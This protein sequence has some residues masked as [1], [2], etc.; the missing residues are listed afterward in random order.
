MTFMNTPSRQAPLLFAAAI[1]IGAALAPL[2]AFAINAPAQGPAPFHVE[3]ATIADIQRAILAHQ[4][5][6]TDLVRLYLARIKAFNGQAVEEPNGILEPI[7]TIPHAR[8]LNALGTL[9]LRPAT[10]R[11]M[12]FDEHKARSMTDPVDADPNMPDAFEVAAK[13]DAEFARTGRLAGPLHGVVFAIKDQYDTFDMRTTSGADAAYAN[14]RP[15]RDSTF[16][17]RLREA[18]AIILAKAN[19]GEYA[20]SYGGN[21]SSFGGTVVNAYDTERTPG[22]SSA[23]SGAAVAA[24]LVS[25]AMGE[26]TSPSIRAPAVNGNAVG[27]AA[28]QE[29]VS[30]VG[31]MNRGINTRVGPITRTV[32]DAARVLSVIAGYD[33][34]DE[35]TAFSV[36]RIP[37]RT[38]ESFTHETNLKGMRI[39]IVREYM[40]KRVGT[41]AQSE[42]IDIVDR[43]IDDLRRLGAT[44][45]DPGPDG[46][47]TDYVRRYNPM[48]SNSSWT[49]QFPDLFPVDASGKPATDQIATL[50]DLAFDPSKVPGKLT[51]RDFPP[52]AAIGEPKYGFD[53]YLRE[54]GD[55]NIK[56]LDDLINK[57]KFYRDG[58]TMRGKPATLIAANQVMVLDTAVRLQRRFAIQ[59]IVLQCMAEQGLDAVV[60]PT[61]NTPAAKIG[62]PQ[63]AGAGAG[64]VG[65]TWSFLG[66][67]G[68]PVITVP[69]G[70][71]TMVYD[72]VPDPTAPPPPPSPDGRGPRVATKLAEPV[73][74]R[75]PVGIDILARPFAEPTLLKIAAA[76]EQATHHR[77]PPPDFGSLADNR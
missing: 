21:R 3:E 29:L 69:A 8:G 43:A 18:G 41:K 13:L 4:V 12:G 14:D 75:L 33:P 57:A 66:Q 20:G 64:A 6:C 63:G 37:D 70:F 71:T 62:A 27:L 50:V 77:M 2:R 7:R 46:L 30:R 11:A 26:E 23:G 25:C 32:E 60:Y 16:V 19:M 53:T 44:I 24:N 31:M 49:K 65:G 1:A 59:Q 74:A 76:Y 17:A 9:N 72:S 40:D 22:A 34:K 48:L 55:A 61:S 73:P 10:R 67:Q 51:I 35:M 15:P 38:Y 54:R 39:G 56:T 58:Q 47:F 45:V 36:G 28:T 68:F 42:T 5:T 52:A